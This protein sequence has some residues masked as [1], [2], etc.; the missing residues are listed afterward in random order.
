MFTIRWV[1]LLSS[2]SNFTKNDNIS[3]NLKNKKLPY[4]KETD[5]NNSF[6]N[7]Y[8]ADLDNSNVG[9]NLKLKNLKISN[10]PEKEENNDKEKKTLISDTK[11]EITGEADQTKKNI[12]NDGSDGNIN[13]I[14]SNEKNTTLETNKNGN[15]QNLMANSDNEV[16]NS[17][18]N[19]AEQNNIT[20]IE[21]NNINKEEGKNDKN[22]K[23]TTKELNNNNHDDK[24]SL[25]G[26]GHSLTKLK[27]NSI[28]GSIKSG[29]SC[30]VSRATSNSSMKR[31]SYNIQKNKKNNK[32]DI[33]NSY[34][35]KY[36]VEKKKNNEKNE[37]QINKNNPNLKEKTN[38][39]E[40]SVNENKKFSN[41]LTMPANNLVGTLS[42]GKKRKERN[43]D[44]QTSMSKMNC[45]ISHDVEIDENNIPLNP[46]KKM[47]N[48]L[49]NKTNNEVNF[50][51]ENATPTI[52]NRMNYLTN[53]H[54]TKINKKNIDLEKFNNFN[55]NF[56][57]YLGDIRNNPIDSMHSV[58]NNRVNSRL[59]EI[60]VG[61]S[62]KEYKNYVKL[63]KYEDRMDDDPATPNAYENITNAKFQAKYNLWR[64]KLHKFDTIN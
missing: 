38:N 30:S 12:C 18:P 19:N 56:I 55:N 39:N 49:K 13:K 14:N 40:P 23:H 4:E 20:N 42:K 8:N 6:L 11:N 10:N 54:Q 7:S 36:I 37:E 28:G 26:E 33:K 58:N 32:K 61:K 64:K 41:L 48:K 21:N 60:A 47:K 22:I 46:T 52:F 25:K 62:T 51:N 17:T 34:F 50:G 59:K 43:I 44:D 35:S 16:K 45:T 1:D 5:L 53:Q 2:E 3:E 57:N 27:R 15:K 24:N 31:N 9:I 29:P 63:V